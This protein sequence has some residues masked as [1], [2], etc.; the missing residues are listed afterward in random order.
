M[1]DINKKYSRL[2]YWANVVGLAL[3]LIFNVAN[4]QIAFIFTGFYF[5]IFNFALF[6]KYL[7]CINKPIVDYYNYYSR[8]VYQDP[9][10]QASFCSIDENWYK[11]ASAI[12]IYILAAANVAIMLF[13][14]VYPQ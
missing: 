13:R 10:A 9:F 11:R 8:S 2:Q 14:F 3:L 6:G 4:M 5:A 1:E 7:N 12:P